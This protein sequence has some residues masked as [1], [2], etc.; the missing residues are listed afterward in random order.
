[1]PATTDTVIDFTDDFDPN[2]WWDASTKRFTPNVAGYY[3]VSLEGLWT[4]GSTAT[5][6]YNIQIRK[7]GNQVAIFQNQVTTSTGLSTGTWR[8]IVVRFTYDI[9]G[10]FFTSNYNVYVNNSEFF[11]SNNATP[12]GTPASSNTPFRIGIR[13]TGVQPANINIGALKV[14]NRVLTTTEIAQNYNALRGRFGL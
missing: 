7:N 4:A 5:E 10:G 14:Y 9:G 6:Q 3:N 1:M 13:P 12:P 2:N 11:N 8:H